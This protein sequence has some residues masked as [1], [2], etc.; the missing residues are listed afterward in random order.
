ML[1]FWFIL[2][3]TSGKQKRKNNGIRKNFHEYRT[4]HI[5]IYARRNVFIHYL[6]QIKQILYSIGIFRDTLY[7]NSLETSRKKSHFLKVYH[8]SCSQPGLAALVLP[9][10]GTAAI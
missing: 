5:N 6:L 3:E 8:F 9:G 10:L 1:A 7:S 4:K 2:V